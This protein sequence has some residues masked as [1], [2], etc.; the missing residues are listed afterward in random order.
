MLTVVFNSSV[1]SCINIAF[2]VLQPL[3][4]STPI[5]HGGL[6]MSPVTIGTCLACTGIVK[7]AASILCFPWLF[8]HVGPR[9]LNTVCIAALG[10]CYVLFPILN[11]LARAEGG[12][13]RVVWA[14][15]ILQLALAALPNMAYSE[16]V[17]HV[18]V[19][20]FVAM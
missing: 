4:L 2:D 18:F 17:S 11:A 13:T 7:G 3:I 9:R 10:G 6:G 12:M 1:F 15:Y 20:L 19:P 14:A 16:L 5:T 8:A